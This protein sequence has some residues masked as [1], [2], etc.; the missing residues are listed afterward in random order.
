MLALVD[1]LR[2]SALNP[3]QVEIVWKLR[4]G[5]TLLADREKA[6]MVGVKALCDMVGIE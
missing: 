3:A 2:N 6:E 4:S 1:S 5:L